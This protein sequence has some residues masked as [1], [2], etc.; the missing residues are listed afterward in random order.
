MAA[1][2][3]PSWLQ[4][5]GP[6]VIDG[7]IALALAGVSLAGAL[8]L[9]H[10]LGLLYPAGSDVT[11][12][13]RS[14]VDLGAGRP[15]LG[16]PGYPAAVH[17]VAA[18]TGVDPL[19]AG[20]CVTRISMALA[21]PATY[22]LA[23][24]L[25]AARPAAVAAALLVLAEPHVAS[26]GT[27]MQPD[28]TAMVVLTLAPA[29]ALAYLRRPTWGRF[30]LLAL[31]TACAMLIRA[32]L[33]F[34]VPM[35]ALVAVL[36]RAPPKQ[37]ILRLA[38]LVGALVVAVVLA[39][40]P[41]FAKWPQPWLSRMAMPV[42]DLTAASTPKYWTEFGSR[43]ALDEVYERGLVGR[44]LFYG[45]TAVT[46]APA[47]W[48]GW[49]AGVGAALALGRRRG[50]VVLAVALCAVPAL[51][52]HSKDRHVF[53]A[54]PVLAAAMAAFASSRR[55]RAV[56]V[57]AAAAGLLVWS[58]TLGSWGPR[59]AA[60]RE[61]SARTAQLSTFSKALC[62]HLEPGALGDGHLDAFL[63][64]PIPT[65]IPW[66]RGAAVEW[67]VVWAGGDP[68]AGFGPLDVGD[69][70]FGVYRLRPDLVGPERPC[71]GSSPVNVPLSRLD[72][73]EAGDWPL[74]PPCDGSMPAD[75]D[76]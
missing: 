45:K 35:S 26:L 2:A 7:V 47:L 76:R 61:Q 38:L 62:A 51:F 55:S 11:I 13:V 57:A 58:L 37:R 39:V 56:M 27:Q 8:L 71:H 31:V 42:T 20:V 22:A 75:L 14:A 9:W 5:R 3:R 68:P 60:I 28:A 52:V 32:Q 54:L 66:K 17:L 4:G 74:E 73:L 40:P 23:R 15:T 70:L 53:I 29:V 48:L 46:R 69:D 43:T 21:G 72:P 63:S 49:A 44:I 1:T 6:Q 36:G 18:L 16:A 24:M 41:E 67:K 33:L 25:G 65:N 64:C 12:W 34:L 30:A 10:R 59:T 19:Q 50:F